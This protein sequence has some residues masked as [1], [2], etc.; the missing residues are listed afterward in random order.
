MPVTGKENP[1]EGF[2]KPNSNLSSFPIKEIESYWKTSPTLT[3]V[4]LSQNNISSIPQEAFQYL[5]N[6]IKIDMSS[7]RL[8]E[9]PDGISACQSLKSL[10]LK[11]NEISKIEGGF[12]QLTT[13]TQVNFQRNDLKEI[14]GPWSQLT[15]L[16][17]LDVSYNK[18]DHVTP[19]LGW[20]P[21]ER[22]D[23]RGNESTL[24]IP[25]RVTAA[26]LTVLLSYLQMVCEQHR[27]VDRHLDKFVAPAWDTPLDSTMSQEATWTPPDPEG[28]RSVLVSRKLSV[29][30]SSGVLDLR[31]CCAGVGAGHPSA[32]LP[33]GYSPDLLASL[34]TEDLNA[35]TLLKE[36]MVTLSTVY[37]ADVRQNGWTTLPSPV[38]S[39]NGLVVLNASKNEIASVPEVVPNTL[40]V[41][42]LSFNRLQAL[43]AA[44]GKAPVLQQM[45]LAGN[46]L[47]DL[48]SSFRALP[49][50]D[51]FLSENQF[52]RIPEAVLGMRNLAK[53]SVSCCRLKSVPDGLGRVATLKFLDFSF[54]NLST[55]PHSLATLSGLT[56]LNVSFNPLTNFPSVICLL[57]SL[58]ELNL[59]H[60]GPTPSDAAAAI[61]AAEASST[62]LASDPSSSSS[63]SA[64]TYLAP[65][66]SVVKSGFQPP[67]GGI[68]S[69]P[70][71][72]GQLSSLEGLQI[73][74]HAL[75]E[76]FASLYR[77]D[78]L[79]LVQIHSSLTQVLNLSAL[80]LTEIP[81]HLLLHLPELRL[82]DLSKNRI[83]R[84]PL[85]LGRLT[86]LKEL[87]IQD[88]PLES[89][90]DKIAAVS[91][92]ALVNFLNPDA[93]KLDLANQGYTTLPP[94]LQ[95]HSNRLAQLKLAHNQLTS[96]PAFLSEFT[97]LNTLVLDNNQLA[98]LP[99]ST[100]A[101]GRL[102]IM[103]A[104]GNALEELPEDLGRHSQLQALVVQMNLIKRIPDSIAALTDLKA[105][106][107]A[108]NHL[109]VLP[110]SLSFCS[111]LRLLDVS[112][113]LL[114]SLPP[115]LGRLSKLKTLKAAGNQLIGIPTSFSLLKGLHDVI[116]DDNIDLWEVFMDHED[117][118]AKARI[119]RER[120]SWI[121]SRQ[122]TNE[123]LPTIP[124][125]A[126]GV[127][128]VAILL[129]KLIQHA[130]EPSDYD[131]QEKP[132]VFS[133]G[134]S[135][136]ARLPAEPMPPMSQLFATAA[137]HVVPPPPPLMEEE[138]SHI[139]LET[140]DN[141]GLIGEKSTAAFSSN[142]PPPPLP[143]G[144]KRLPLISEAAPD[145][146]Q[147]A[148]L[149]VNEIINL[150]EE[151]RASTPSDAQGR[152]RF[153]KTRLGSGTGSRSVVP[154]VG[155]GR[156][157]GERKGDVYG[158]V[159]MGAAV[160]DGGQESKKG[161]TADADGGL[162]TIGKPINDQSSSSFPPPPPL[163]PPPPVPPPP[164][165]FINDTRG[166]SKR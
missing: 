94:H 25:V 41:L 154:V 6:V 21:M 59:D 22:L 96:L 17:D 64:A 114:H 54:N 73:E 123:D 68:R 24:R 102:N 1:E 86:N 80:D 26:G 44:V 2:Y 131:P 79:L 3:Y 74:G 77:Q 124:L 136:A 122:A 137:A 81:I 53:L 9:V 34:A 15:D 109:S 92:M 23:L 100:L 95:I 103:M 129:K 166:K 16:R 75:P 156:E 159:L 39:L 66:A 29:A 121:Q 117:P 31:Q 58:L 71:E 130:G 19:D 155:E 33:P 20:L 119:L 99:P 138:A 45:Y 164:R 139:E 63:S 49:M 82:L 141:E 57:P 14:E 140:P 4:N 151:V 107:I 98:H 143:T 162:I 55:L 10:L 35:T 61:A 158:D 76:P 105:F 147:R 145:E 28:D 52:S 142:I 165:P 108:S 161:L 40:G 72:I 18:L 112:F 7:N 157:D 67:S 32:L 38:I 111:S 160:Q 12:F 125:S 85:E 47:T 46:A 118:A 116:F 127:E 60:V 152:P 69:L 126:T 36:G 135:L 149:V 8:K 132:P 106:S 56:A 101:L 42:N 146:E 84:P 13:L 148:E 134:P 93:E 91:G 163:V 87:R 78:P 30:A 37:V 27:L 62:A 48:P 120:D 83:R 110:A 50:V 133:F 150:N 104:S 113:N 11:G 88:N 153:P 97:N 70:R 115:E 65:D 144:E 89:P 51:L 5:P 43:P 90:F 128:Q